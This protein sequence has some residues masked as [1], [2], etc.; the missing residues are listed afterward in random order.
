[1][2]ANPEPRWFKSSYSGGSGTE[3]VECAQVSHGALIRDSKCGNGP[4]LSVRPRAWRRF[5]DS[6]RHGLRQSS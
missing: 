4:I 6:V 1:M 2:A 5:V 3:C